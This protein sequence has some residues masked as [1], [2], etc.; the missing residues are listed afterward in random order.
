VAPI[1]GTLTGLAG[2]GDS[3]EGGSAAGLVRD[4]PQCI[5][6]RDPRS[7]FKPQQYCSAGPQR[8][9]GIGSRPRQLLVIG[10]RQSVPFTQPQLQIDEHLQQAVQGR[11]ARDREPDERI[12]S[13][14]H[15]MA[16][17]DVG[18]FHC[19]SVLRDADLGFENEHRRQS[20]R[21]MREA[22]GF[23]DGLEFL[24]I[25]VAQYKD[26]VDVR[27]RSQAPLGS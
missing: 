21:G 22:V 18:E 12:G 26:D 11:F 1:A 8:S 7:R 17:D 10:R 14:E 23:A 9:H 25:D 20:D 24:R 19:E 13:V 27:S 16:R 4:L 2:L 15:F 5:A 6:R 3:G